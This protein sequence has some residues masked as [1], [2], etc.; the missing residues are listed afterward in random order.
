MWRIRLIS[1]ARA[2]ATRFSKSGIKEKYAAQVRIRKNR[3]CSTMSFGRTLRSPKRFSIQA[4]CRSP[5][6]ERFRLNKNFFSGCRI[7]TAVIESS[8]HPG[9][10]NRAPRVAQRGEEEAGG[11]PK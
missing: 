9:T 2:F 1:R 10:H 7:H 11:K 5:R 8:L 3:L 6:A 4:S